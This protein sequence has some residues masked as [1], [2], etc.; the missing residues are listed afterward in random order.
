VGLLIGLLAAF[1]S[2]LEASAASEPG[3]SGEQ[4]EQANDASRDPMRLDREAR[5]Q[6]ALAEYAAGLRE[7]DRSERLAR[8]ARAERAFASLVEDGV[9]TAPLW[10]NLGNA[11][12]QA[13][14]T[15]RAVLA[16]QRALRL[17]FDAHGARQ[18]LAHVRERLPAWVPRPVDPEGRGSGFDPRRIA[19]GIRQMG[20]GLAFFLV[21]LFSFLFVRRGETVWRALALLSLVVWLL[22]VAS[23]FADARSGQSEWAV[24]TVDEAIAR[25]ADS[26]L[27]ALALPDPLPSGVEVRRLERRGDWARVRLG[28][29]RDVWVRASHI[30]AVDP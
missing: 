28:N 14:H 20:A 23:L 5:L 18:N 7:A 17:D 16:Y 13:G 19:P 30:T 25:S 15:G 24:V 1:G 10:T 9:E 2:P 27:A 11:A 12:L 29:G 22:I 21:A 3:R 4:V 8:F 6:Q 26:S